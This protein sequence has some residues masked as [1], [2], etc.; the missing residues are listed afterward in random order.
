M[1][2]SGTRLRSMAISASRISS[3]LMS[4][5][6]S[7]LQKSKTSFAYRSF[8]G[9]DSLRNAGKSGVTTFANPWCHPILAVAGRFASVSTTTPSVCVRLRTDDNVC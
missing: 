3:V 8:I 1:R 9:T 4:C 6:F 5:A 2:F 7:T